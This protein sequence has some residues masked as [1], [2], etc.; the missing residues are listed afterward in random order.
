LLPVVIDDTP[1]AS[2]RV[3]DRFRERQWSRLPA[4]R[5]AEAFAER[6]RRLMEG[7]GAGVAAA[8]EPTLAR[9]T[10]T[11]AV[12]KSRL[13][14]WLVA[15]LGAV[16]AAIV[17]FIALRAPVQEPAIVAVTKSVP[18]PAPAPTVPKPDLNSVA[19]LPFTNLSDDK[20]NEYFSDGISEELLSVLQ[21]ISGLRVAARLSAFSFKGKN[22]TAQEIGEKL[23]VAN[24]VEGSVR[25]SGK[26]V[27]ISVRLSRAATGEQLWSES[28]TRDLKNIFAVQSELAQTIVEQL[29][30]QL[31]GT[32][33]ASA[34]A[35][36]EAQVRAAGKGGTKNAEAYQLYLQGIFFLNQFSSDTAVRAAD[37]LERAIERDPAFALAWAALS[38]GLGA[39]RNCHDQA[40]Y[41]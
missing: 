11:P 26:S 7:G 4:G 19:V 38:R 14:P 35:E 41:R 39:R 36:I 27:R 1:D 24:L 22:A 32:L 12:M 33:N 16:A 29:R 15:G 20:A 28:Y 9:S 31:G 40:R 30:G 6:A 2:A 8:T 18:E 5:N 17:A 37:F 3:P 23:G 21:K 25:K 34:K 13:S 10:A